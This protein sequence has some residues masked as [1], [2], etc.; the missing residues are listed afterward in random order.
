[1]EAKVVQCRREPARVGREVERAGVGGVGAEE[2]GTVK[3]WR[4]GGKGT[5]ERSEWRWR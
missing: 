1:M 2:A 5:Q 4:G 3:G